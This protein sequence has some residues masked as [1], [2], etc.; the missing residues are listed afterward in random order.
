VKTIKKNEPSELP[1]SETFLP[2][3]LKYEDERWRRKEFQKYSMKF[4]L[5]LNA[6]LATSEMIYSNIFSITLTEDNT[7]PN[8]A[9]YVTEYLLSKGVDKS[10]IHIRTNENS[11]I[12]KYCS[13]MIDDYKKELEGIPKAKLQKVNSVPRPIPVQPVMNYHS[14]ELK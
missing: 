4:A 11:H 6:V 3:A 12:G 8:C 2:F 10:K 1:L 14:S 7:H 13:L 9:E 5:F